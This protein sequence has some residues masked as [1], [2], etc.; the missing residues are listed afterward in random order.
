MA[1][2][3]FQFHANTLLIM[4]QYIMNTGYSYEIRQTLSGIVIKISRRS[5]LFCYSS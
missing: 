4:L 1:F 5:A 2:K 3:T